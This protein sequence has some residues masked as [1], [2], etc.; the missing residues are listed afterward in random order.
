MQEKQSGGQNTSAVTVPKIT[1]PEY[2]NDEHT[3]WGWNP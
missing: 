3:I 2:E 1:I